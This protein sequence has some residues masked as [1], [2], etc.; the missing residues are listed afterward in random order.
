MDFYDEKNHFPQP[1]NHFHNQI[2]Q[3][4]CVFGVN[5]TQKKTLMNL[6]ADQHACGL[7][8]QLLPHCNSTA[9]ICSSLRSDDREHRRL[10][11]RDWQLAVPLPRCLSAMLVL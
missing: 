10:P 9:A 3:S 4:K 5:D 2:L 6:V 11:V 8:T 7:D 1:P